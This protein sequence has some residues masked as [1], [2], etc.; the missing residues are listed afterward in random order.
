VNQLSVC[1]SISFS[2]SVPLSLSPALSCCGHSLFKVGSLENLCNSP[3]H[4]VDA[5]F[6]V[7]LSRRETFGLK[8]PAAA[9]NC[10][11]YLLICPGVSYY[12]SNLPPPSTHSHHN[13]TVHLNDTFRL[14]QF[15]NPYPWNYLLPVHSIPPSIYRQLGTA[16]TQWKYMYVRVCICIYM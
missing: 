14:R 13:N 8:A 4:C 6:V 12:L 3:S 16:D 9:R 1:L 11:L 15:N 10:K 2:F 5:N 7:P